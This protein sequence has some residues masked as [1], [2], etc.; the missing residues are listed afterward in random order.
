MYVHMHGS[1]C[2][3][4]HMRGLR[5]R[6]CACLGALYKPHRA[7]G[8]RMRGNVSVCIHV[9]EEAGVRSQHHIAHGTGEG[10]NVGSGQRATL[11]QGLAEQR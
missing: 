10:V 7:Q 5:A 9:S 6:V 4:L 2:E 1:L 8:A 3:V 11:Y